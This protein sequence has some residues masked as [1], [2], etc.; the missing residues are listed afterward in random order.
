[1]RTDRIR[2]L[3]VAVRKARGDGDGRDVTNDEVLS[4]GFPEIRSRSRSRSRTL[5]ERERERERER[6]ASVVNAHVDGG[7]ADD[8]CPE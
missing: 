5:R 8:L 6:G 4:A 1:M 2:S 3:P 7:Y